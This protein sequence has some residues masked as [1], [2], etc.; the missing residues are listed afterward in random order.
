M[1]VF[2][3]YAS[4]FYTPW[5]PCSHWDFLDS[6]NHDLV[7]ARFLSCFWVWI[8][9]ALFSFKK[10]ALYLFTHF[11][12]DK[13]KTKSLKSKE[14]RKFFFNFYSKSSG[15]EYKKKSLS[16]AKTYLRVFSNLSKLSSSKFITPKGEVYGRHIVYH[17]I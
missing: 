4:A 8:G 2:I 12:M 7:G 16:I 13:V 14:L 6:L 3:N 11:N 17:L 15:L 9:L 1:R 10:W 5:R